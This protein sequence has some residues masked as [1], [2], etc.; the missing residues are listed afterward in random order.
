M[1]T[2]TSPPEIAPRDIDSI[3]DVPAIPASLE[4]VYDGDAVSAEAIQAELDESATEVLETSTGGP[5]T[6]EV[7]AVEG[8][9]RSSSPMP[10]TEEVGGSEDESSLPSWLRAVERD[11][12]TDIPATT[13]EDESAPIEPAAS[14]PG[15]P[16]A[17]ETPDAEAFDR[18]ADGVWSAPEE[19]PYEPL[20]APRWQPEQS[21]EVGEPIVQ[22]TSIEPVEFGAADFT[23]SSLDDPWRQATE[24]WDTQEPSESSVA[25]AADREVAAPADDPAALG[26]GSAD[27][28]VEQL[29]RRLEQIAAT[30][31]D[32]GPDALAG[33]TSDPLGAL[34]AAYLLG[35]S[36]RPGVPR[37]S[38]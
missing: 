10:P 8:L 34:I 1:T 26:T 30:L 33:P 19:V 21:I 23:D 18:A 6:T 7:I 4:V 17:E 15:A 16:P 14:W 11:L 27:D 5:E 31:R 28:H 36:E 38:S 32:S 37:G 3:P 25:A 24:S 22:E 29:A 9:D 2:R 13:P 12:E 35:S 20:E